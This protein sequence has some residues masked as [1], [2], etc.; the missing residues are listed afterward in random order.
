MKRRRVTLEL[1]GAAL[2]FGG[3]ILAGLVGS[4]LT[5][6]TWILGAE[7]H[8]WVRG[9][10][11]A[12]LIATIPLLIFAGY[13]LD[14]MERNAK[15]S[16]SVQSRHEESGNNG[17][18]NVV[19]AVVFFTLLFPGGLCAHQINKPQTQ[20]SE[21][22]IK[23]SS[24]DPKDIAGATATS[25]ASSIEANT[26]E[27]S[28]P[29]RL[30]LERIGQDCRSA[31][32]WVTT[33]SRS[34]SNK[35]VST[36]DS[37]VWPIGTVAPAHGEDRKESSEDPTTSPSQP[38]W[39]HGGFVDLGY[40]LDFNHPAN[41]LF[42]S[43][44]P[45]FRVDNAFLNMA[46]FYLKKKATDRSRWGV[47]LTAQAG[48][49]AEFFGFSATAPNI[50]GYKVLRQL[51][52]TNVSY[53]APVG[54]GLTFQ[55]G[56]FTSLI[57]YDSLYAKD[58]FSYTR[59]WGADFTPY[60]MMGANASYP[61]NE[62]TGTFFVVNGYWHLARANNVP[63]SGGQIAYKVNPRVTVKET[64][65]FGPHQSNN[66]FKFWRFLT[67]TIL[68]R[69]TDRVIFAFEYT[70]SWE[71]VDAPGSPRALM[72][73]SQLPMRWGLNKRWA[74]AVRPEVFWDRDGRWTLARQTV[75]AFTTTLEYRLPYRWTN[76]I[77]RLEHRFDDSRGPDGGFFRG[78][79]VVPGVVGLTPSQ[80]VLTFALM[81]T[82]DR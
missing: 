37:S 67:D 46:A 72:M 71:R 34:D 76:T 35:A 64:V 66:S 21:V 11:T 58:N 63:S 16:G 33:E 50:G 40:L 18:L 10:G 9:L 52:P 32:A 79:E 44:G 38:Q 39:Q 30:L 78:R 56:I 55:A 28:E 80:H 36:T 43:R 17:T 29:K 75:K 69:K 59:P 8:P 73:S 12:L 15:N 48:K 20:Q 14:W 41:H 53:L 82:V 24:Q 2:C 3:G 45:T 60:F 42:R 81:F 5:A 25:V 70:A 23:R 27:S 51:G 49:D 74:L 31:E 68:E 26:F 13:C 62:L 19:A 22:S 57:G 61:F 6:T 65:L 54:E 47:E 7:Q 77:F 4:L 1:I